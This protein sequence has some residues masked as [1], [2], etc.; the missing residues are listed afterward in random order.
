MNERIFLS[1]PYV[2]GDESQK[3]QQALSSNWI[4]PVG[5]YIDEFE[6]N[7]CNHSQSK[8]CTV[9]ITGTAALH[10]ALILAGVQKGDEV[11][12]PT[13]TFVATLNPI[14]YLQAI[15]VFVESE[16]ETWGLC[17]DALR[18]LLITRKKKP[19]VI[20]VVHAYGNSAK[21]SELITI[22]NEFDIPVIE[23]AAAALGTKYNNQ[24][25]G[26][27]GKFGIYSFN[28][29]KIITTSQGGAIVSND[30]LA[31]QQSKHLS[32][33]SKLQGIGF[34]HDGVGYNYRMSN[35]LA[36]IGVA[37]LSSIEQRVA[38][39]RRIY[40]YYKDK[41]KNCGV[42]ISEEIIGS[43]NNRWLSNL[44]LNFNINP[45]INESKILKVNAELHKLN[46]ESRRLWKPLHMQSFCKDYEYVGNNYSYL[47]YTRGL[48]LPSGLDLTNEDLDKICDCVII[49]LA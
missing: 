4:A 29:N 19:K 1:P 36:A 31:I 15:P 49:S 27:F 45:M 3:L 38:V 48:S 32:M 40:N 16:H 26:T 43:K 11:I 20:I 30:I 42:I 13:F 9:T 46:I 8:A 24:Q 18:D 2:C 23:D 34:E 37:Q 17:P 12:L 7:I 25:V 39:K 33:Q 35:V 22:A 41:L 44:V 47:L 14:L 5:S 6:N 21:I 28:G 10:L